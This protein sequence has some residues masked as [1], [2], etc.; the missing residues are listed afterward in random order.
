MLP[1]ELQKSLMGFADKQLGLAPGR[2]VTSDPT[3]AYSDDEQNMALDDLSRAGAGRDQVRQIEES[4]NRQ[5]R[6]PSSASNFTQEQYK[7]NKGDSFNAIARKL[8]VSP[9]E[10]RAANPQIKN[11]NK[12]ASGMKLN[13]PQQSVQDLSGKIP[14]GV[15]ESGRIGQAQFDSAR[16]YQDWL[17]SQT[18]YVGKE[19]KAAMKKLFDDRAAGLMT[20]DEFAVQQTN[21]EQGKLPTKK[22]EGQ[23]KDKGFFDS[24]GDFIK[25]NP[26]LVSGAANVVSG[27]VGYALGDKQR[28]EALKELE[29][30]MSGYEDI[31][32]TDLTSAAEQVQRSPEI[33]AMRKA[34][35]EGF[36]QRAEMGLTPEDEAMLRQVQKQG[37]RQGAAQRQALTERAIQQGAQGGQQFMAALQAAG[38]TQQELSEAQD[39]IASESFKAKQQ[40]LKELTGASQQAL[41]ED[42]ARDLARS[43]QMD[44]IERFNQQQKLAGVSGISDLREKRGEMLLDRGEQQARLA[45]SVGQAISGPIQAQ[46]QAQRNI[47]L[48]QE[49]QQQAAQRAPAQQAPQRSAQPASRPSA[50]KQSV[51][52]KALNT[53]QK[54]VGVAEKFQGIPFQMPKTQ[55]D[56]IK[57]GKAIFD[58]FKG[59]K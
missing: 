12:I 59:K 27:G 52:N 5:N 55:Q 4:L 25:D 20:A 51:V 32:K 21:I 41:S 38:G 34:G 35:L 45:T 39:R 10:L 16:A 47:E 1:P 42:F 13:V 46:Q 54:A 23:P 26:N 17:K 31:K 57:S 48:T 36:K 40:A 58:L 49:P 33:L 28:K 19:K 11:I 44:A 22:E 30:A 18:G 14:R 29:R 37:L 56:A 7:I 53:A 43:E 6:L 15:V 3:G 8:G 50:K 2:V 9:E 24:V